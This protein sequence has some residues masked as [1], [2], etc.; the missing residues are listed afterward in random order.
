MM[1]VMGLKKHGIARS[2][3]CHLKRSTIVEDEAKR[4][5][6][7]ATLGPSKCVESSY[8]VI[9]PHELQIETR[10]GGGMQ[11]WK[12]YVILD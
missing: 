1:M 10:G 4:D 6:P 12:Q 8:K 2:M 7:I 9:S 5:K 11:R 3:R